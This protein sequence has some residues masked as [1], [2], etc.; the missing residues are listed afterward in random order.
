MMYISNIFVIKVFF[1]CEWG[2]MCENYKNFTSQNFLAIQYS[3]KKF[4]PLIT[5]ERRL[6]M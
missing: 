2:Q 3:F 6:V 1:F 5:D 4:H